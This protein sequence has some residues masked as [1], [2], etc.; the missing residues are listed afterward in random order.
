MN[1]GEALALIEFFGGV[2]TGRREDETGKVYLIRRDIVG[3]N[4]KG[5]ISVVGCEYEDGRLVSRPIEILLTDKQIK[6]KVCSGQLWRDPATNTVY[7]VLEYNT[8]R[9]VWYVRYGTNEAGAALDKFLSTYRIT[10]DLECLLDPETEAMSPPRP[11]VR[12]TPVA[13]GRKVVMVGQV[14]QASYVHGVGYN[15]VY[16][17]ESFETSTTWVC[18]SEGN[19]TFRRIAEQIIDDPHYTGNT[20]ETLIPKEKEMTHA[21]NAP[22]T[23]SN[24]FVA[25]TPPQPSTT[26]ARQRKSM[27]EQGALL[28][29][30]VANGVA[31]GVTDQFGELIVGLVRAAGQEVGVPGL[32]AFLSTPNGREIAK[33][34]GATLVHTIACSNPG[35]YVPMADGVSDVARL[36]IQFATARLTSEN[37]GK[38]LPILAKM[39]ELGEKLPPEY[40]ESKRLTA[41]RAEIAEAEISK[42]E[43]V[44]AAGADAR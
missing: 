3:R 9:G 33:L 1:H 32:D 42:V 13:T 43:D 8:T 10:T 35:G 14:R 26:T 39:G 6:P 28:G 11:D 31:M 41:Q 22:G 7:K 36:Q 24:S 21:T 17:V 16:I 18:R 5:E 44:V 37:M 23:S 30:A 2:L 29:G 15:I 38:I 25:P 34:V 20:P 27:R 12:T 4:A 40:R 19:R